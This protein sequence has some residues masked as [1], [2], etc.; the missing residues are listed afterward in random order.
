MR[1][2]MTARSRIL[3]ILAF[4]F[5]NASCAQTT[6]K[7]STYRQT[8]TTQIEI[9]A[10]VPSEVRVSDRVIGITPLS[11]PFN[12]EEEV[13]R[14]VRTANYWETNPGA[15][16]AITVLS[17]GTYLPFSLIPAEPTSESRPA[18]IFVNTALAL[19]LSADGFEPLEHAVECKGE[20][21]IVLNL[22]LKPKKN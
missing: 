21:K 6:Y 7:A 15:A 3:I 5:L 17:F 11:F 10:N 9:K 22:S 12:Y 16:A 1:F 2:N 8:V 13:D 20:P 18:G 4:G 19:R 14:Q